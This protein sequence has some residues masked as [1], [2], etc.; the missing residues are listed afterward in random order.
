MSE[1]SFSQLLAK[2][3]HQ[4]K[5]SSDSF[6]Q[7]VL[8]LTGQLYLTG[9]L[10]TKRACQHYKSHRHFSAALILWADNQFEV[11]MR[12]CRSTTHLA[13]IGSSHMAAWLDRLIRKGFLES[14]S[15]RFKADGKVSFTSKLV[16]LVC[17]VK[18]KDAA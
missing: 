17:V 18:S 15:S 4:Q 12:G 11:S 2:A 13:T 14:D 7:R 9:V 16:A 10:P 8:R 3:E 6:E 5:S 1:V